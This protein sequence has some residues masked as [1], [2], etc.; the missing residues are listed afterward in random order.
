MLFA[1]MENKEEFSAPS[2]FVFFTFQSLV[3]APQSNAKQSPSLPCL[4]LTSSPS[5]HACFGERALG[6]CDACLLPSLPC[7]ICVDKSLFGDLRTHVLI[8]Y[9][10]NSGFPRDTSYQYN[11]N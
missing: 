3:A 2:F 4:T 1:G 7:T 8:G 10:Y 5:M 6:R 9:I 11:L